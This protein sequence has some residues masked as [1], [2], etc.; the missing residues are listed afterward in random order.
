MFQIY[1]KKPSKRNPRSQHPDSDTTIPK[2]VEFLHLCNWAWCLDPKCAPKKRGEA[3][4]AA[5]S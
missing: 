2:P 4:W 5:H 1:L 3:V